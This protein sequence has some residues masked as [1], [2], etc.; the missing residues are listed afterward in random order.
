MMEIYHFNVVSIVIPQFSTFYLI[1]CAPIK[2]GQHLYES[3]C[4]AK[5]HDN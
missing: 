3:H 5:Y 4:F 2:T 1:L